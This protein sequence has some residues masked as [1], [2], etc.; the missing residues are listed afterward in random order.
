MRQ[1]TLADRLATLLLTH[2]KEALIAG[3]KGASGFY[4]C[5]IEFETL[6]GRLLFRS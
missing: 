4:L 6:T 2:K 5:V 1:A 3:T